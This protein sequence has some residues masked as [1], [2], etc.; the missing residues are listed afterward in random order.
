MMCNYILSLSMYLF[1]TGLRQLKIKYI[2]LFSIKSLQQSTKIFT[3]NSSKANERLEATSSKLR[4]LC[5]VLL[6]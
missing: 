6:V 4:Y 1:D 3:K 2:S 5:N